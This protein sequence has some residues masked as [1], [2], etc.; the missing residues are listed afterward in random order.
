MLHLLAYAEGTDTSSS[1]LIT[2]VVALSIV[3]AVCVLAAIPAAVARR[4]KGAAEGFLALMILWGALAAGST[5][6]SVNASMNWQKEYNR[7]VMSGY[8]DPADQSDRPHSPWL[9]W[10]VLG[11]AYVVTLVWAGKT[12][13][14]PMSGHSPS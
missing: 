7:R 4:R 1:S 2:V 6:Y 14:P 13:R 3:A 5:L 8:F 11:A 12:Q 9:L 10:G